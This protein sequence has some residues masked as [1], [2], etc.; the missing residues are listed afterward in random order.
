MLKEHNLLLN[1]NSRDSSSSN[2]NHA[3]NSLADN[4]TTISLKVAVGG[5][6]GFATARIR[7]ERHS[8]VRPHSHSEL[9]LVVKAHGNGGDGGGWNRYQ[10][11]SCWPS[12]AA[13]AA[14]IR[15]L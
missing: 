12:P 4:Y 7:Y 9:L 10:T 8:G 1:P 15:S 14:L 13:P 6:E 2:A 3:E 11:Y 5:I